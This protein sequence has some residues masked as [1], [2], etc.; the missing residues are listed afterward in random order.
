[1]PSILYDRERNMSR[2]HGID[3][4]KPCR[5]AKKRVFSHHGVH[6]YTAKRND[7]LI[8]VLLLPKLLFKQ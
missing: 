2:C 3:E 5:K 1:M 8:P 7:A 6:D 4:Q